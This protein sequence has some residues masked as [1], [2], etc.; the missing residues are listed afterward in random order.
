MMD[1]SWETGEEGLTVTCE[2][3]RIFIPGIQSIA[4]AGAATVMIVWAHVPPCE[5]PAAHYYRNPKDCVGDAVILELA[6]ERTSLNWI[7]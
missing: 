2:V 4:I 3:R 1:A 7:A 6:A 5:A